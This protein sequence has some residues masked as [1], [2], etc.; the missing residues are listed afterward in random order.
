VEIDQPT[1]RPLRHHDVVQRE[2]LGHWS[3]APRQEGRQNEALLGGIVA[4]QD[5]LQCGKER[6]ERGRREE[7]EASEG[8][9]REGHAET[10]H[11]P[12]DREQRAVAA[13]DDDEVDLAGDGLALRDHHPWKPEARGRLAVD[14]DLPPVRRQPLDQPPRHFA[15]L[16][17]ALTR[18]HPPAPHPPPLLPVS[19]QRAARPSRSDRSGSG[20]G[21][22]AARAASNAA[23]SSRT[24]PAVARWRKTSRFP[25][26]PWSTDAAT[27]LG[28]R[29]ILAAAAA[30][31]RTASRP[32]SPP[33]RAPPGG[34]GWSRPRPPPPAWTRRPPRGSR[35]S[36][37]PPV[38]APTSR[39]TR[40]STTTPKASSALASFSP[41]LPTK[42][43]GASRS[44]GVSG[45]T[46]RP[47]LGDT[48][49]G[50]RTW[51]ARMS[52]AASP[53]LAARPRATSTS[54]SRIRGGRVVSARLIPRRAGRPRA[55]A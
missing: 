40:P 22:A 6:L 4:A 7:A 12:R 15:R 32:A 30:T 3:P 27:P 10:V 41:P 34:R 13:E 23:P 36:V 20:V 35:Q 54:S 1:E 21:M 28:R 25:F 51:P 11:E 16:G 52:R 39:Q 48:P 14:H 8:D 53:R 55:A 5:G 18:A 2:L 19:A 31:P 42:G 49:T 9:A 33:P 43:A 17:S 37:N 44:T 24:A 29:P 47:G 46:R 45:A 38:D 50:R 26:G